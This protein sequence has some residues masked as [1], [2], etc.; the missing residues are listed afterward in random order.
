MNVS[1]DSNKLEELNLKDFEVLADNKEKNWFKR[2]HI[3]QYLKIARI[4]TLTSK[5][6]EEI[7]KISSLPPG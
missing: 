1:N 3:G 5:L 2:A 6:S 4:I 7:K